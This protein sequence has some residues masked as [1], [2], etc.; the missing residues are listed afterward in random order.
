MHPH[1]NPLISLVLSNPKPCDKQLEYDGISSNRLILR[2]QTGK[3]LLSIKNV[4]TL[5]DKLPG[6]GNSITIIKNFDEYQYLL[7]QYVPKLSDHTIWKYKFQ[8]IR[9]LIHL[10]FTKLTEFLKNIHSGKEVENPMNDLNKVGN[11]IILEISELNQLF[12][13]TLPADVPKI[14]I[15]KD[16][17]N[18]INLKKNHFEI[19]QINEQ[20]VNRILLSYYGYDPSMNQRDLLRG[21]D[22]EDDGDY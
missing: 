12:R 13:E 5:K 9:L 6:L 20:D 1:L 14:D 15:K 11:D 22:E 4:P 8:K 10:Y 2:D 16:M 19:F 21:T 3:L 17:N 18:Q 7:C